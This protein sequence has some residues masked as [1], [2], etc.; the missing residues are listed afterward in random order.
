MNN[1]NI[2]D[3]DKFIKEKLKH[4]FA[5]NTPN[6]DE[7]VL[8]KVLD[9]LLGNSCDYFVKT[10]IES[11]DTMVE[12]LKDIIRT[13]IYVKLD[14]SDPASPSVLFSN[15]DIRF[16]HQ[17]MDDRLITVP[18]SLHYKM[19]YYVSIEAKYTQTIIKSDHLKLVQ[20]T[21]WVEVAKLPIMVG[22]S[23][24][25]S[26]SKG[27]VMDP[28]FSRED[29]G[30]YFILKGNKKVIF[31]KPR[32][33]FNEV[34]IFPNG[35]TSIERT[36]ASISMYDISCHVISKHAYSYPSY[37]HYI[38]IDYRNS[39]FYLTIS[40]T[41]SEQSFNVFSVIKSISDMK[42]VD[43]IKYYLEDVYLSNSQEE[44]YSL[45]TVTLQESTRIPVDSKNLDIIKYSIAHLENDEEKTSFLL[46]CIKKLMR[47]SLLYEPIDVR[48][49]YNRTKLIDTPGSL[50]E[51]LFISYLKITKKMMKDK[52]KNQTS[53]NNIN[54]LS[55][56][57]IFQTEYMLKFFISNEHWGTSKK[58]GVCELIQPTNYV[59]QMEMLR[60]IS[61]DEKDKNVIME[62]R[63]SHTDYQ[64]FICSIASPTSRKV[65]LH[66]YLGLLCFINPYDYKQHHR[67]INKVREFSKDLV[68]KGNYHVFLDGLPV[69]E[70]TIECISKLEEFVNKLKFN[71]SSEFSP[72]IVH[73]VDYS[74]LSMHINTHGGRLLVPVLK[75]KNNHVPVIYEDIQY[76]ET[77]DEFVTRYPGT[78]DY[79][80]THWIDHNPLA[81]SV[82]EIEEYNREVQLNYGSN[83]KY[84]YTAVHLTPY[85]QYSLAITLNPFASNQAAIRNGHLAKQL[86]AS[87]TC[88]PSME[89]LSMDKTKKHLVR[90]VKPLTVSP[91]DKYVGT[92]EIPVLVNLFTEMCADIKNQEDAYILNWNAIARGAIMIY[93]YK[94]YEMY[95]SFK[96][97]EKFFT[98][99]LKNRYFG[100]NFSKLGPD[101]IIEKDE[102][103]LYGDVLMCKIEN[104]GDDS[105]H[106]MPKIEYYDQYSPGRVYAIDRYRN[107][108]DA[109]EYVIVKICKTSLGDSGDKMCVPGSTEVLTPS[110]WIRIDS[111]TKTTL[112]ATRGNY[113]ELVFE[114]PMHVYEY[115]HNGPM[116]IL[117]SESVDATTTLNHNMFVRMGDSQEWKLLPAVELIGLDV[118]YSQS[119]STL[120]FD[121]ADRIVVNF[122]S[123]VPTSD[124]ISLTL[125]LYRNIETDGRIRSNKRLTE[126]MQKI[127]SHTNMPF[128]HE[129]ECGY[130][131]PTGWLSTYSLSLV[132]NFPTWL[133]SVSSEKISEFLK[134]FCEMAKYA[135]YSRNNMIHS[136]EEQCNEQKS[137]SNMFMR[138][139][140]EAQILAI[141]IGRVIDPTFKY[142]Q[143]RSPPLVNK[144]ESIKRWIGKVYCV[145]VTTGIF[146]MRENQKV[147]WTGNSTDQGQKGVI[148]QIVSSS[149]FGQNDMNFIASVK[150]SPSAH[151]RMTGGQLLMPLTNYY[152]ILTGTTVENN[153]FHNTNINDMRECLEYHGFQR[154]FLCRMYREDNQLVMLNSVYVIP[155]S[156]R[157]LRQLAD[158]GNVK[159]ADSG[160]DPITKNPSKGKSGG[161]RIGRMEMDAFEIHGVAE[162]LQSIVNYTDNYMLC[163]KCGVKVDDSV[164]KQCQSNA[165]VIR[166]KIPAALGAVADYCLP[167]GVQLKMH[168]AQ[169]DIVS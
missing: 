160:N 144:N 69:I 58:K 59:Y 108:Q 146:L 35:K 117:R 18:V 23:L 85:A 74:R 52:I 116:Y 46:Y 143:D 39:V 17:K 142:R 78:F 152:A 163:N 3:I 54:L 128:S 159:K 73:Y 90:G 126:I 124:L 104:R 158:D 150:C 47:V 77:L 67:L 122:E 165:N 30:G 93:E 16:V 107:D 32:I 98:P 36:D 10:C 21:D 155:L 145:Q 106:I 45:I 64:G 51:E 131:Y 7:K 88:N 166:A 1:P 29:P 66:K 8:N 147:S 92:L 136:R 12:N 120:N 79:V 27:K 133:Y 34:L 161:V 24:C 89:Y 84:I 53:L 114:Q 86:T 75:L 28:M 33:K 5:T 129:C 6:N 102:S 168:V 135:I 140:P 141:K 25:V 154:D 132:F 130:I 71:Q 83:V 103:V 110:G 31:F 44:V 42:D 148:G 138:L 20:E 14:E 40:T 11:Y 82:K 157:R 76:M 22:S 119:S 113:G 62:K 37:Q 109:R 134:G 13:D 80:D 169:K 38:I 26:K 115:D 137:R 91:I 50:I 121:G 60:K 48:D 101:G 43:I 167:L 105:Q 118:R 162:Y 65:G 68:Q 57:K 99:T 87:I 151:T 149:E 19:S 125:E 4:K 112:I 139:L 81:I 95:I 2:Q 164:C 97:D 41:G 49:S 94:T 153:T 70:T 63:R 15:Q 96:S 72:Y 127:T 9:L 61:E 100:F 111:V 56:L 123:E 55:E 156:F